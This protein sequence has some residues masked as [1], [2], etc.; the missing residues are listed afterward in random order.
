MTKDNNECAIRFENDFI[1]NQ[2]AMMNKV[3]I[4]KVDI[5]NATKQKGQSFNLKV[6]QLSD[7]TLTEDNHKVSEAKG[8]KNNL[9]KVIIRACVQDSKGKVDTAKEKELMIQCQEELASLDDP[10]ESLLIANVAKKLKRKII[11]H[12]AIDMNTVD[13]S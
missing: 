10:N 8:L 11:I 4:P 13:A 3:S 5:S 9:I 12:R 7:F 6:A 2:F 1:R